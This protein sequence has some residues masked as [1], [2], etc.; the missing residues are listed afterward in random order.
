[1]TRASHA[2]D[3]ATEP[4]PG[5]APASSAEELRATVLVYSSNLHTRAAVRRAVGRRP[6][7]SSPRVEWVECATEPAVLERVRAGG[8]DLLVLDGEAAPS[9]GMGV[10]RTLKEEI[11]RCPPVLVLTGRVADGWLASW[12]RADSVVP[13]PLDPFVLARAVADLLEPSASVAAAAR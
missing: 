2:H 12:S 10:C 11:F 4:M 7:A 3:S 1:M 5:A 9:G 8:L 13:H 6:S